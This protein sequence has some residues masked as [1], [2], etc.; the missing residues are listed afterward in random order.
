MRRF[1]ETDQG[2]FVSADM[3]SARAQLRVDSSMQSTQSHS[4]IGFAHSLRGIAALLVVVGHLCHTFWTLPSINSMIGAPNLEPQPYWFT[5]VADLIFPSGFLGHFP[6]AL[7]FLI[8]GFVIPFSLI[9]HNRTQFL[10]SRFLRLWPTYAVGLTITC[11]IIIMCAGW[12]GMA[13]PF[14]WSTYFLQ[15]LFI[16]DLAWVPTIDGIVWTLEIEAKFYVLMFLFAGSLRSGRIWPLIVMAFL[17]IC[18]TVGASILPG[19][20]SSGNVI[21]NFLYGLTLSAQ[22]I[23]FM[24]IG[25]AFNFFYRGCLSLRFTVLC[26][27]F[28]YFA[29]AVQWPVGTIKLL[30]LSGLAS[31]AI[32]AAAFALAFVWRDKFKHPPRYIDWLANI[33]YPLYVI[34]AV[35]GWA[36]MRMAVDAGLGLGV[37]LTIGFTFSFAAA[38]TLHHW[39]ERPSQALGKRLSEQLGRSSMPQKPRDTAAGG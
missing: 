28:F 35:A 16:R 3:A 33:S 1:T 31:Y 39:I 26:S 9:N 27:A 32:A 21:Y 15:L 37:V 6:V 22:M 8:S 30:Y 38:I 34:H 24:F 10:I 5:N 11:L 19:W 29:L 20:L 17:L 4:K 14:P 25:V 18:L 13:Q 7:F 23:C 12:F 36:F 2:N